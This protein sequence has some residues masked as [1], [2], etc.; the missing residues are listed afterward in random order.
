M[1]ENFKKFDY[2]TY[3][4]PHCCVNGNGANPHYEPTKEKHSE[5]K[6]GDYVLIDLWAKK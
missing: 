6:K 4:E 5:I 1:M 2:I 3:A